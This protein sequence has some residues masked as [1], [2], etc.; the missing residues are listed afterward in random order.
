[1]NTAN[2]F[3]AVLRK[4]LPPRR[5]RKGGGCGVSAM[6]HCA[7][8]DLALALCLALSLA[9]AAA[10]ERFE[11]GLLW[12]VSR[13][14]VPPSFLFGTM[15]VADPRLL[16]LPAAAEK[17]FREA[18]TFVLEMYPDRAVARRF[19]E[20]SHLDGGRRLSQLMTP[21]SFARLTERLA[22]RGLEPQR[23]QGLKPWAALLLATGIDGQG[24]E[25]LDISLYVRARFANKRIEE[26]DSVEEQIAVFDG[27]PLETQLALLEVALQRHEALRAELEQGIAAYRRGDLAA[28][29]ELS[30]RNGGSTPQGR[31]HQAVLEKKII[32]DRSVVMAHRL[33]AHLRRGGA[34]V[35]VGA[36]HLHGSKG[37]P[38][39]LQAEGWR[40]TAVK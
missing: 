1:M 26:L 24:A 10:G 14:G 27:I 17:A 6:L 29:A 35:A 15:H 16:D 13:D 4:P 11:H 2:T 8:R 23:L 12:R 37:L 5:R 19:S 3:V 33:Q 40:V 36:L 9:Q 31:R 18:R 28:L 34:F 22:G 38:A 25:S 21:A 20:A 30:R 39:L 32:H 7:W